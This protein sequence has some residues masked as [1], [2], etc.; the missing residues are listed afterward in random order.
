[1]IS[2]AWQAL[3][4]AVALWA[5]AAAPAEDA[6]KAMNEAFENGDWQQAAARAREVVA[7]HPAAANAWQTLGVALQRA[8]DYRGAIEAFERLGALP[9]NAAYGWYSVA[10][11]CA[12]QGDVP[13]ALKALGTAAEGGFGSANELAID[14]SFDRVRADPGFAAVN[15]RIEA[16]GRA[17]QERGQRLMFSTETDRKSARL[18][19][20]G[21]IDTLRVVID[22][23]IVPWREHYEKLLQS[24]DL[25]G[26]RWRMGANDW[27]TLETNV[28]LTI[29]DLD[30][31]PG[32]YDLT[33]RRAED[34]KIL[35]ELF[36]ADVIRAAKIDPYFC[37]QLAPPPLVAELDH[38][39][40][41]DGSAAEL[42]I[43]MVPRTRDG[44]V[45]DLRIDF[46]PHRLTAPLVLGE[47]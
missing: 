24:E 36:D 4:L 17:L 44:H 27:T 9:G 38:D 32:H 28:P 29:G 2:G 46:G 8:K 12:E 18:V 13:G 33:L 19:L 21:G 7:E 47:K 42:A 43:A 37:A 30:V 31:A 34:G 3:A 22:H 20:Y 40:R 15:S 26:R 1:M 5:G 23:G 11:V 39:V 10:G 41:E 6:E 35:L 25:D 45:C 14:R 16:N